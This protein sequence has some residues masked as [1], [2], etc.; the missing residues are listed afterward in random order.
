MVTNAIESRKMQIPFS[1]FC[2]N[3][4]SFCINYSMQNEYFR[5][6]PDS[7]AYGSNKQE[8]P[9]SDPQAIAVQMPYCYSTATIFS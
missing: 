1:H 9:A 7:L 6:V 5:D 4:I 8:L 2:I 3:S